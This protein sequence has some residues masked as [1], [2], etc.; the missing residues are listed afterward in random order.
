MIKRWSPVAR[1]RAFFAYALLL[2]TLTHWPSLRIET[3][4]SRPDLIIHATAF[5][6]WT[7]LFA[8][9]AFFGAP[10]SRRNLGMCALIGVV[11]ACIDEALQGLRFINRHAAVDDALADILGV[12]IGILAMAFL[13]RRTRRRD[14]SSL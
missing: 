11:Y 8:S 2:F 10:G 5:A 3:D 4:V 9:C 12:A 7:V 13:A 14:P 1:R 6:I